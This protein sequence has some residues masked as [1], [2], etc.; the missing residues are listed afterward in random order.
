MVVF[1]ENLIMRI[2]YIITG[3]GMGGAERQVCDLADE[4]SNL[5]NDVRLVALNSKEEAKTFPK[6]SPVQ[7]DFLE[8]TKNPIGLIKA[9]FALKKIIH[10][11]Q[12]DIVHCHMFHANIVGRLTRL[13]VKFPKLVCTAHNTNEGG[14]SRMLA[15]RYSNWLSDL[16]TNVSEEAVEAFVKRQAVKIGQMIA[17][18]NGIDTERFKKNEVCRDKLRQELVLNNSFIFLAVGRLEEQKDYPN[19]L[20]AFKLV[21][22]DNTA[23]KLVI[24][25]TGVLE[26]ELKQLAQDL[27]ISDNVIF[28]G[29]RKDIP[30]IMNIADTY[31]L[32]SK[33]EGLPLVLGEAMA[34]ENLVVATDCGG[35]K[36]MIGESGFLVEPQN[37]IALSVAMKKSMVLPAKEEDQMGKKARE[38]IVLNYSL[39][40]VAKKWISLYK[41][42]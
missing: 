3:L 36:E 23:T 14:N 42:I 38:H 4:L 30:E 35:T 21:N 31:V 37:H 24:V 6:A 11:F 16:N 20:N 12:P 10:T 26:S 28:L 41:G 13:F 18:P 27:G 5:G 2:L 34:T 19:L 1:E 22:Q 33:Y 39:S 29:L 40:E 7:I 15:Y 17:M 32:S 8:M 9:I 25:G